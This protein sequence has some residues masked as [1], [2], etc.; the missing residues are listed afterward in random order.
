MLLGVS[1]ELILFNTTQKAF[2][3]PKQPANVLVGI[4]LGCSPGMIEDKK[5]Q[6]KRLE[7]T[8]VASGFVWK[9]G[10]LECFLGFTFGSI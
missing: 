8:R 6:E 7:P 5:I 2:F 9:Q 10:S 3:Q 1:P 4:Q